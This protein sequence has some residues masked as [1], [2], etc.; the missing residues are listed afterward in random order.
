MSASMLLNGG[1]LSA[2]LLSNSYRFTLHEEDVVPF[3]DVLGATKGLTGLLTDSSSW[4]EQLLQVQTIKQLHEF[5]A[6][7]LPAL[8]KQYPRNNRVQALLKSIYASM[9]G[10]LVELKD[11]TYAPSYATSVAGDVPAAVL[12]PT[13]ADGQ[14]RQQQSL[15]RQSGPVAEGFEGLKG[16]FGSKRSQAKASQQQQQQHVGADQDAELAALAALAAEEQEAM[17]AAAAVAAAIN[18]GAATAASSQPGSSGSSHQEQQAELAAGLTPEGGASSSAAAAAEAGVAADEGEELR[19]SA[20]ALAA[21]AAATAA[22]AAQP[23]KRKKKNFGKSLMKSIVSGKGKSKPDPSPEPELCSAPAALAAHA[24]LEAMLSEA[25]VEVAASEAEAAAAAA[26]RAMRGGGS[27]RSSGSSAAGEPREQQGSG[28]L[29]MQLNLR[30]LQVQVGDDESALSKAGEE[31]IDTSGFSSMCSLSTAFQ[32][33][34]DLPWEVSPRE[35]SSGAAAAAAAVPGALDGAGAAEYSPRSVAVAAAQIE[36]RIA[37]Q[38]SRRSSRLSSNQAVVGVG[39]TEPPRVSLPAS[40]RLLAGDELQLDDGAD[41]ELPQVSDGGG[42]EALDPVACSPRSARRFHFFKFRSILQHHEKLS[43]QALAE[44]AAA[45]AALEAAAAKDGDG[46][47][48]SGTSARIRA[49]L[50]MRRRTSAASAVTAAAAAVDGESAPDAED[51]ASAEA[52]AAAAAEAAAGSGSAVPGVSPRGSQAGDGCDTADVSASAHG[53]ADVP[54]QPS[55]QGR[56]GGLMSRAASRM[57]NLSNRALREPAAAA[58]TAGEASGSCS[59]YLVGR[60][61]CCVC[62]PPHPCTLASET[63]QL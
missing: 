9:Q 35:G 37:Q 3:M 49:V 17:A 34:P 48:V 30:G 46:A 63:L 26:A 52:A 5:A 51:A 56:I 25:E 13:G 42:L 45:A 33:P 32:R 29:T 36:S 61:S 54:D 7:T 2:Y 41:F 39:A 55:K 31:G 38:T 21:Y 11:D 15:R 43:T 44:A 19:G 24:A 59:C 4:L 57:I 10:Q 8:A 22:A 16:R 58:P 14:Q 20:A 6:S 18:D 62:P 40:P 23:A 1:P 60:C 12:T 50:S 47:A 53:V 27:S 28:R